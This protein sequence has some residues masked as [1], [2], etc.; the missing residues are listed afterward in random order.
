MWIARLADEVGLTQRDIANSLL[1][2]LSGSSQVRPN[3]WLNT[4]NGVSYPIVAQ[5][6]QYRIDLVS[7]LA[8]IPIT[9]SETRDPRISWRPC[10]QS[11]M[12]RVAA[13]ASHY[14]IEPVIDIYAAVQGRDLGAVARDINGILEETTKSLPRGILCGD[15]RP[16]AHDDERLW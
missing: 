6:P 2:T 3:F 1:V 14:N 4:E 11:P 7:D 5:V 10:R 16:G 12:G 8:N 15:T 9:S 13:V